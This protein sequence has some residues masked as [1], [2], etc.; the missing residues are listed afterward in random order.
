MVYITFDPDTGAVDP[1]A[2][3][4]YSLVP[5]DKSSMEISSSDWASAQGKDMK[6]EKGVF[7]YTDPLPTVADYDKAMEDHLLEE[8]T[9]R[10]Y[11]LREPSDYRG[12]SVP[13]WAQD[14]EDWIAHRDDVMLYGLDVMNHYAETGEAPTLQEFRDN[15]P[16]IE[17]T[18]QESDSSDA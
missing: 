5:P 17:W 13:R 4:E 12:S 2:Y 18:Y 8:R 7:T 16:N 10:G 9:A 15:M 1:V 6:V 3:S 14:A 11:T